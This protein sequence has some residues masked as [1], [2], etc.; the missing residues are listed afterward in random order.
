MEIAHKGT[1]TELVKEIPKPGTYLDSKA[2]SHFKRIAKILISANSLKRVHV[3]ALEV[4]AENFS[5][6]EW[7][8]REIRKKNKEEMG[9]GYKQ[10]YKSGAENISV[11]LTIKRD[12][13]KAI[14]QC[15]KQFGLDPKSEKELKQEIDPGQG[16]LFEGFKNRKNG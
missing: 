14:M 7:A 3:P 4:M 16:D 6:W 9:T 5:Q 12:A 1:G 10:L 15:F 2:K 13:E 8:V 11:E